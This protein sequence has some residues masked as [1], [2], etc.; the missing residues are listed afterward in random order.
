[1]LKTQHIIVFTWLCVVC[2]NL[3]S[4]VH[5]AQ[6]LVVVKVKV[7]EKLMSRVVMIMEVCYPVGREVV[8]G[9]TRIVCEKDKSVNVIK[10][11]CNVIEEMRYMTVYLYKQIKYEP[12]YDFVIRDIPYELFSNKMI[13]MLYWYSYISY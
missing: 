1:M 2:N 8:E 9:Q 5:E 6:L 7:V 4:D 13:L 10:D 11:I 12:Y 3:Y